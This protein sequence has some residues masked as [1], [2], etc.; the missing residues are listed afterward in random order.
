MA[1]YQKGDKVRVINRGTYDYETGTRLGNTGQIKE[2]T[3][4]KVFS[5]GVRT[6]E[7]GYVHGN[8]LRGK[9]E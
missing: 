2:C 4:T 3:V 9:V 7:K 8:N 1:K 5:H 6:A